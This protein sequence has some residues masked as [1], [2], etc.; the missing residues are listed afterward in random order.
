LAL[1]NLTQFSSKLGLLS[2]DILLMLL[3]KDQTYVLI[4]PMLCGMYFMPRKGE[5]RPQDMRVKTALNFVGVNL[6]R[7]QLYLK[8]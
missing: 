8:Y 3:R 5:S 4:D 7:W 2:K 1:L 6:F